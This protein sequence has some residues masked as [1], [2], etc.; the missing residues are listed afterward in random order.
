MEPNDHHRKLAEVCDEHMKCYSYAAPFR[1]NAIATALAAERVADPKET[2]REFR[3]WRA[4]EARL[5]QQL[6]ALRAALEQISDPLN[7][8]PDD[9]EW[10]DGCGDY[11]GFKGMANEPDPSNSGDMHSH[12]IAVGEWAAAKIA[13]V[14]LRTG[15][16]DGA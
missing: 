13:R 8:P 12:G 14:A 15:D 9:W 6:A 1:I 3:Q 4:L 16:S 11:L 5:E 7:N 10:H 2:E